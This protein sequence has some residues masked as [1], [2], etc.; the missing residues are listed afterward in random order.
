M[1]AGNFSKMIKLLIPKEVQESPNFQAWIASL[2][3]YVQYLRNNINN[4]SLTSSLSG[5]KK[6]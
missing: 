1:M 5:K 2:V 6:E 4:T 3:H